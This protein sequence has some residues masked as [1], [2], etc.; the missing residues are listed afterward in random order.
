MGI[1]CSILSKVD[2]MVSKTSLSK[3]LITIYCAFVTAREGVMDEVYR[4]IR[5]FASQ[6]IKAVCR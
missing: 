3:D 2:A 6:G 1:T 4:K 5:V